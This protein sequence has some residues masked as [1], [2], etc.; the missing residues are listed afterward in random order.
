MLP[1]I[2]LARLQ[3]FQQDKRLERRAGR[4]HPLRSGLQVRLGYD[5]SGG[6]IQ[7]DGGARLAGHEV[8]DDWVERSRALLGRA[9]C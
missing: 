4:C 3:Q 2:E 9:E 8:G 1:R 5:L 6:H 7:H